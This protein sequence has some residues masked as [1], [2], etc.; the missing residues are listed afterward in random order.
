VKTR[1][2]FGGAVIR[3]AGGTIAYK[4]NFR[5]TVAGPSTEV[6]FMAAY[7]TG[8][9]I[10]FVQSVIWDLRIP[11]EVANAQ[12][13]RPRTQHMDIK[14]FL[15]CKWVEHDLMHLKRINTKINMADHLIKGL[16][17]ALFHRHADFLLGHIP[18]L[19]SPVNQSIVGTYTDQ[20]S[21]IKLHISESFTT[22]MCTAAARI[23]ALLLEDYVGNPW[24]IV[25]LWHG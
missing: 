11:Q 24:L 2:S 8:K 17:R 9:M 16:T 3:L 6:E 20:F 7:N 22:P 19:Y 23:H 13:P 5:P 25:L 18:P 12:K 14:Y 1:R 10:L 15:L 4:C 21:N